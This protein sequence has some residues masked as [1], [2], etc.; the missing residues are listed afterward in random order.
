MWPSPPTG[1]PAVKAHGGLAYLPSGGAL[2]TL[3]E[4]AKVHQGLCSYHLHGGVE[5]SGRGGGKELLSFDPTSTRGTHLLCVSCAEPGGSSLPRGPEGRQVLQAGQPSPPPSKRTWRRNTDYPRDV[6]GGLGSGRG[7]VRVGRV[8]LTSTLP[9]EDRSMRPTQEWWA[10]CRRQDFWKACSSASSCCIMVM[11]C[12][13][14][15][16]S[17]DFS[18]SRMVHRWAGSS[19][20]TDPQGQPLPGP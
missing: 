19:P 16:S 2:F 6:L 18:C 8:G 4:V 14:R 10:S 5:A 20:G 1:L 11:V 15:S 13:R 12:S 9:V 3:R 7:R 17:W